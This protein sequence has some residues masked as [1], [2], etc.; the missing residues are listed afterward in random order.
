MAGSIDITGVIESFY[1]IGIL[2]CVAGGLYAA[3]WSFAIR[4]TMRVRSYRRQA[5]T[6][7]TVSLYAVILLILF[8][9]VDLFAP[10][11]PSVFESILDNTRGILYGILP[12]VLLAWADSSVR[13]GRRSDPLLRD[14]LRWSKTRR[15]LWPLMVL[16]IMAFFVGGGLSATTTHDVVAIVG[17]A[18]AF[19]V[20]AISVVVVFLAA[21]RSGDRNY[22]E[23][24]KWFGLFLVLVFVL[25]TGFLTLTSAGF[26]V[27]QYTPADF[28]WAIIA[29]F[30]LIPLVWYCAYECSR[31]LVPLNRISLID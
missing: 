1:V 8:Y 7:G 2:L 12:P 14:S 20:L 13:V 21:K 5:L 9:V 18:S 6:V 3:Y 29:N 16:C 27:F 10:S 24:L 26:R 30:A 19:V 15:V 17:F 11:V 4:R 22:R 23:S 28:T 31:S 25:N